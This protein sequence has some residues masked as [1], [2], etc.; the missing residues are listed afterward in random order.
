MCPDKTFVRESI[1]AKA[2]IFLE[3]NIFKIF[4]W[5]SLDFLGSIVS[6]YA[7]SIP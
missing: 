4:P 7:A 2:N 6:Y 1:L 5:D 3:M